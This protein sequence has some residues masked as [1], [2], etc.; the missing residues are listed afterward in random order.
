MPAKSPKVVVLGLDCATPQ[1]V[2]DRFAGELEHLGRLR[3]RGVWGELTSVIPAITVP[4]WACSMTSRDPG[5]LGI[6]GF[7]NRKD[8]SYDGLAFANATAVREE[9]VW[10]VLAHSGKQVIL[11]SV[12]PSYPPAPVNGCR[13]GCFLTPNTDGDYTYPS[14][15]KAEIASVVGEYMI[16]VPNFRSEEKDRIVAQAREMAVRRFQLFR[17]LLKT[18]PWEF[19]MMV[20]IGL[21]RIHHGFWQHFDDSHR[22][23][24]PGNPYEHTVLEY[25]RLLDQEIGRVLAELDGD[26][27]VIVMSD[28]GAKSMVGGVCIN[29]WLI[30]EGYLH[31]KSYPQGSTR[32]SFEAVDWSRTRAW[33][34][35]G[36]YGRVF[37]NVQ[38]REPDGIV[39]PDRYEALR[40][41][42]AAKLAAIPDHE[43]RPM[44]TEVY[45]PEEIYRQCRNVP[46]DLIVYFGDLDW[47]AVA[48]V[49]GGAVHTFENDTGPDGANHAREGIFVMRGPGVDGGRRL[50]GLRLV[51]CG[52]TVLERLDHPVPGGMIGRPI[53]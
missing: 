5:Q 10:D 12:P 42:L 7:R 43:G 23:Y 13:V 41:E 26:T 33:G 28:H 35:G 22:Q 38:G 30:Q 15:L 2:F 8:Y 34:E 18:R 20:E 24:E 51:D 47:R 6:Y 31:L 49:G 32:F 39:E 9:A 50:D 14:Q 27:T 3:E 16:D 37:I 21:D 48:Q 52:P 4:A 25:Y 45:K 1:L 17:H 46:P 11:L 40:D 19:A 29:E 44:E 36:Y 53:R